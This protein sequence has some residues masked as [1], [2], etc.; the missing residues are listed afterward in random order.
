MTDLSATRSYGDRGLY[1]LDHVTAATAYHEMQHDP[2]HHL[3]RDSY[4]YFAQETMEQ[5]RRIY[6]RGIAVEFFTGEPRYA[7]SRAMLADVD[8]G[9]LWTYLTGDD[10]GLPA[11]HPMAERV[12]VTEYIGDAR[13]AVLNDIFRAVHDVNGH[14]TSRG[15]FGLVGEMNAWL[16]HRMQYSAPAHLALWCETRGQSAWTNA[17]GTNGDLPLVERPFAEQKAGWPGTYALL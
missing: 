7:D 12:F 1:A 14:G 15:S 4:E 11:D 17:Y 13:P 6:E 5:W 16:A 10:S 9:H 2:T 8:N 3:V